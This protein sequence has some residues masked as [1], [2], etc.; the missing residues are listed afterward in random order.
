MA[1]LL[2]KD[3]ILGTT[4][5]KIEEVEVPEWGG[6]VGIK[7]MTG[8]QRDDFE[9]SLFVGEGKNRKQ[10][11]TNLRARLV[12]MTL[13]G[14][15]GNR[16]FTDAEIKQLSGKS[17]AALSRCFEVAQ[18]LNGMEAKAVEE[19]KKDSDSATSGDSISD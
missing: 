17:A 1:K 2:S 12:G 10:N 7:G 15:D 8:A 19:A 16:L 3:E 6:T 4:D 11:M 14:E 13:V 5:L 9:S 18:R